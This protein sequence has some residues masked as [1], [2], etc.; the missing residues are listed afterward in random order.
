MNSMH[1]C[2]LIPGFFDGGAQRQ[3]IFL[4]NELKTR[5]DVR[6]SVL[7]FHDG[8]HDDLLDRDGINVIK[9]RISSNYDPRNILIIWR[10]LRLM[11][12]DIMITW[13]HACDVYGFFL[14]RLNPSM[15]WVM[16]ERDSFYPTD[17]RYLLRRILGRYADSIV[18]NSDKGRDY[19][20]NARAHCPIHVTSNIINIAN[21][22]D[23]SP[24]KRHIIT[25]GRLESQKNT[26]S[27]VEAF[28][29]LAS[30][31]SDLTFAVIGNGSERAVLES[32]LDKSV[33]A[34]RIEFLGFRKDIPYQIASSR[35]VVS[36]SHHEGLPNVMLEA[37][38]GNRISVVSDIP[39]HRELFGSDYPFF[40][41]DRT[42][43]NDI[44]VVIE[45][46]L[47]QWDTSVHLSYAKSRLA[48]MTPTA[49]TDDYLNI[50]QS[51]T[52]R[53]L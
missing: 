48:S 14:K 47:A 23:I 37:V 46:A 27:V 42:N 49:V 2:F 53:A 7:Y 9:L 13:M 43:P 18:A 10:C 15:K 36:M 22:I 12:P 32:L 29:I 35:I 40:V 50:F 6:V 33:E 38:A 31:H 44:A 25:V 52:E 17:I 45:E 39:E 20:K 26:G 34:D 3:C 21:S 19:W 41:A 28:K 24:E 51:L 4:I 5:P 30:R 1:I 8:V 16:T 11:R